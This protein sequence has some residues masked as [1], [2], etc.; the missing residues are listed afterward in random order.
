VE[1]YEYDPYGRVSVYVGSSATAV[2]ASAYGLPFLW[3]SVRLDEITG[4]LQMRH[5]YYSVE[6]GR[7]LTRDP[8]GV[9]GDGLN[10]GNEVGYAGNRPLVVGDPLG[11]QG[12][13]FEFAGTMV[14]GLAGG[15]LGLGGAVVNRAAAVVGGDNVGAALENGFAATSQAVQGAMQ[16]VGAGLD[17]AAAT[18]GVGL[19]NV[20]EGIVTT[21]WRSE[22]PHQC[23]YGLYSVAQAPITVPAAAGAAIL[24][25]N[26]AVRRVSGDG[27]D[28]CAV[29]LHDTSPRRT[30]RGLHLPGVIFVGLAPQDYLAP[31]NWG[32]EAGH[33][34][35]VVGLGPLYLPIG[36][37]EVVVHGGVT[38]LLDS[39]ADKA[40]GRIDG[41]RYPELGAR[42]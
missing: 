3:K 6:L 28:V 20:A 38:P 21:P 9:W 35:W 13:V 40:N 37:Y 17:A 15:L 16:Q 14:G 27:F 18:V 26:M 33:S 30:Y 7:F 8:L 36:L 10:L 11:L 4:L 32:H 39:D 25:W 31:Y 41:L 22:G 42:Y 1:T 29:V 5:R 23:M 12:G 24:G 34:R 19:A 2:S